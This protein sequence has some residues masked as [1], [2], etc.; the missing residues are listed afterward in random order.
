MDYTTAYLQDIAD[1]RKQH[2]AD[3]DVNGLAFDAYH[4][5]RNFE[6]LE[7]SLASG[8]FERDIKKVCDRFTQSFSAVCEYFE[9]SQH[10]SFADWFAANG[11]P[12]A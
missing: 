12:H 6:R 5:K 7:A 3:A 1:Y 8:E 9:R 2:G 4:S 11:Q 10:M